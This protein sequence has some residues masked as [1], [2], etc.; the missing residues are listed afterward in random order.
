MSGPRSGEAGAELDGAEMGMDEDDVDED[1]V[2]D[3]A[4]KIF[5][6][7]AQAIVQ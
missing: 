1:E 7:I 6:R 2:I 4:E 3:V 5:I